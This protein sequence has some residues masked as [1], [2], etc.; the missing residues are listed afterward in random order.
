M[1]L[2]NLVSLSSDFYDA[3]REVKQ[4]AWMTP[5]LRSLT[6]SSE[7]DLDFF[8]LLKDVCLTDLKLVMDSAG[9][10]YTEGMLEFL[11]KPS[12]SSI[13]ALTFDIKSSG[14]ILFGQEDGIDAN[15]PLSHLEMLVIETGKD[16][17]VYGLLETLLHVEIPN[18]K[19][20][21]LRVGWELYSIDRFFRWLGS[22]SSPSL[23][24]VDAFFFVY[25]GDDA[26]FHEVIRRRTL[27]CFPQARPELEIKITFV[28]LP[29]EWYD[30]RFV[31]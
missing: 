4:F 28:G 6:C 18:L 20:L 25:E 27:E 1:N 30:R 5:S 22:L 29:E 19:H 23:E 24:M 26:G 9:F 17:P 14:I 3:Y 15:V 21:H 12:V 13:T 7:R 10:I 16:F 31:H 8:S 2:P 11:T